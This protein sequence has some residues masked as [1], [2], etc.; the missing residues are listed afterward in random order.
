M[1]KIGEYI[2]GLETK[3]SSNFLLLGINCVSFNDSSEILKLLHNALPDI[4][5]LVYPNSGESYEYEKK[6]WLANEHKATSWD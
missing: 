3:A 4:P 1:E 2:K 5:W 6:K